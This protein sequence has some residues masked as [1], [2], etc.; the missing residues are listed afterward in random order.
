MV[1]RHPVKCHPACTVY[2]IQ[3][4][5]RQ[6]CAPPAC[7]CD[8]AFV[9][10]WSWQQQKQSCPMAQQLIISKLRHS[11][12]SSQTF[13]HYRAQDFKPYIIQ[14]NICIHTT[15]DEEDE[16]LQ[17]Q[18][19]R[20]CISKFV[21]VVCAQLSQITQKKLKKSESLRKKLPQRLSLFLE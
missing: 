17:R 14:T 2:T 5:V 9:N 13:W 6:V 7:G 11:T 19:L 21:Q 16:N 1:T 15:V 8:S 12:F 4:T 3:C 10:K 20:S 18:H